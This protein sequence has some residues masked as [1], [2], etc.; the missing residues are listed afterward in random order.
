V[1]DLPPICILAGG[2][3]ERLGERVT[4]TPKPLLEVA[5]QP[6]L[7]H[8]LRLLEKSG[9]RD[10]VLCVGY[11]GERIERRVGGEQFG[12]RIAY[13]Y[14]AAGLD[15]TLGAIRRALPLL[16][17]RFLVLYGD[18]YLRMDYRAAVKAWDQS[19][20]SGLMT[21][22]RN[23]GRWDRSNVVYENRRVRAYNKTEPTPEMRWIDYGL[24]GLEVSALDL[25]E[26][27]ENDLAV[28]YKKLAEIGQLCGFEVHQRFY[29]I[30][31]PE[32]L[33]ETELFLRSRQAG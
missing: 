29:E 28:L 18:A 27:N 2:R 4:D 1:T 24:G 22:L 10:V 31:T 19:D 33:A 3:G 26:L 6:F 15:G 8:Q 5:G 23:D 7:L 11:L 21:V 12:I 9:A 13:S 32:S 30:G 17:E 25:V 20:C 16:S 14:D